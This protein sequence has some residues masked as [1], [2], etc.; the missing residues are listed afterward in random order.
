MG[1]TG[2][3]RWGDER[4]HLIATLGAEHARW[5]LDELYGSP[6]DPK[7]EQDLAEALAFATDFEQRYRN[8]LSQLGPP[9]FALMMREL[10][11][12]LDASARPA[13]Y[14]HLLH[15]QDTHDSAAGRLVA[16]VRE[17]GAERGRHFVFFT[18]E[19]A[20]L[21]DEA[22]AALYA[23]PE[24]A[25]YRHTIER[26]RRH[27]PHQ[28]SD[29][30]ER[31]LTDTSPVGTAA[32]VRL[33]GELCAAIQIGHGMDAIS[34]PEALARMR[35][36]DREIRR[37][38]AQEITEALDSTLR[39]RAYVFNV[40]VQDSAIGDSLRGYPTWISSRNLGNEI[41]DQAVEALVDAVTQRNAMVARYYQIKRR[42]LG[43][44]ALFEWDRDAPIEGVAHPLRWDEARDL[45]L[46]V[47]GGISKRVGE[48]VRE[49]FDLNWIDAPALPGKQQ[50]AYC[51]LATPS[52]HPYVM[53]NFTGQ[54]K[55]ALT[56]AHELGHGLHYRL[57]SGRHLFDYTPQLTLAE[58]AS[59]FGET[60]VFDHVLR[61]ELDDRLRLSLLC[62]Q[63]EDAFTTIFRQVA[64]HR[65]EQ[66]VH[67]AR[68]DAGEL[69]TGDLAGL[70]QT[71]L[72]PMFGDSLTLTQGH[73]NWWSYVEHF[74]QTP[75]YVYAYAFGK[76]LALTIYQR[77]REASEQFVDQYVTF[78]SAGGSAPPNELVASLGI[79]LHDPLFWHRGLDIV[80]EMVVEVERLADTIS[81]RPGSE[82]SA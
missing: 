54:L 63:V 4:G 45:V 51:A 19:L 41:S 10:E 64:F 14:A 26:E 79:D 9:E 25:P 68:R 17:A 30:E 38:A 49:F 15:S 74:I 82:A 56:L 8:R 11:R 52:L 50:G 27:R 34:L 13:L 7:I 44:D 71:S 35:N 59:V 1:E 70:W 18:I 29:V 62:Q 32:W 60:L 67:E 55:D 72:Q 47:Y 57:A 81:P 16:R 66:A 69:S 58:T 73:A 37:A 65:F 75:G 22:V 36:P 6:I 77:Y 2:P 28:L 40:V 43:L 53:L 42:L 33:Y 24:A 61:Q 48:I 76:L 21:S 39:T 80:E 23:D 20:A 46:S 12:S 78:L 5:Q 3:S 31:I